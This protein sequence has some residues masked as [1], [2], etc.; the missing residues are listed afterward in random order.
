MLRQNRSEGSSTSRSFAK[1]A[2]L[3]ARRKTFQFSDEHAHGTFSL[4]NHFSSFPRFRPRPRIRPTG[5]PHCFRGNHFSSC[6][7]GRARRIEAV[8]QTEC[9]RQSPADRLAESHCAFL[10]EGTTFPPSFRPRLISRETGIGLAGR[11]ALFCQGTAFPQSFRPRLLSGKPE[12]RERRTILR[13]NHFSLFPLVSRDAVDRAQRLSPAV[14]PL[15]L[16]SKEITK[17]WQYGK[18]TRRCSDSFRQHPDAI[19]MK[20]AEEMASLREMSNP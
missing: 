19:L 3:R 18:R 4:R 11:S 13:G 1:T 10:F 6:P 20:V 12:D 14:R 17:V 9:T 8:S 16:R 15:A 7:S 2:L 5:S